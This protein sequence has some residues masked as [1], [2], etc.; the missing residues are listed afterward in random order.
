[1]RRFFVLTA[2]VLAP[3]YGAAAEKLLCS[4]E[5]DEVAKW[6]AKFKTASDTRY[7]TIRFNYYKNVGTGSTETATHGTWALERTIGD[8]YN[9]LR[10]GNRTVYYEQVRMGRVLGTYGW[11]RRAFP[12]DWTGH[13]LLRLDVRTSGPSIRLRVE[14]E[15]EVIAHPVV[16]IFRVPGGK[17]VTAEVDLVQAARERRLD[18]AKMAQLAAIVVEHLD[19]KRPFKVWLDNIRLAKRDAKAT[20]PVV[21]D[22]SPLTPPAPLRAKAVTFK[23]YDIARTTPAAGAVGTIPITRKP[24]YNLMKVMERA[25]GGFGEGGIIVVNG[26]SAYL[27]L[28][29]GKTWTGLD[30]TGAS[31]RLSC[32]HRGHHRATATVLGTDIFVAYCT[33]KCAGGG[34]RTRNHFTKAVRGKTA[35]QVGPEVA[36]ETGARHCTDRLSIA[37]AASGR[38]W[39]A[40][41]HSGRSGGAVRAKFSDD[42]GETWLDAGLNGLVAHSRTNGWAR[43]GPFLTWFGDEVLCVWRHSQKAIVYSQARQVETHI[44]RVDAVERAALAAGSELGLRTGGAVLIRRDDKTVAT[45]RLV[46]VGAKESVAVIES[47]DRKAVRRDA[48]ALGFAWSA[49]KPITRRHRSC[50]VA[51]GRDGRLYVLATAPKALGKVFCFDGKTWSDDTPPEL[52]RSIPMPLLVACGDRMAC[53][54]NANGKLMVSVKPNGGKWGAAKQVAEEKEPMASLAAPQT[55]PDAFIP[56]AWSTKSRTFIKVVA[57]PVK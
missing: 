28:D 51:T 22:A 29:A 40:W 35:W 50:C 46:D 56:I 5:K 47:G 49:P 20:L 19:G 10:P 15:D 36:I 12:A 3:A 42:G 39:C 33:N 32:D 21:R 1:V 6:G 45:L 31:T 44:A 27:S 8:R 2:V 7:E 25:V 37:R 43:E 11:F 53:V 55:A 41:N 34:G 13:D 14:L 4:F 30:G 16:R 24:S 54:W 38:L 17:W 9:F 18:L 48:A 57:V 26:P 52:T 23:P